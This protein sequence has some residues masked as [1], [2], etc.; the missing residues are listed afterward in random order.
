MLRPGRV[1]KR[2]G[3]VRAPCLCDLVLSGD[4]GESN[5]S[6]PGSERVVDVNMCRLA[7]S[8]PYHRCSS[9]GES[10]ACP[11]CGLLFFALTLRP[12]DLYKAGKASTRCAG[13]AEYKDRSGKKSKKKTFP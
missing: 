3:Q 7:G 6:S 2:A 13:F 4:V 8:I 11:G 5:N 9:S 12:P 1:E 10:S